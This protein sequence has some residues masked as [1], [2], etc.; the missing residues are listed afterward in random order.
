MKTNM[1]TR[2]FILQAATLGGTSLLLPATAVARLR[3]D[4]PPANATEELMREHGLLRRAL[5]VYRFSADRLRDGD[6]KGLANVLNRNAELFRR[7]GEDFHERAI[8]EKYV[9]P[10]VM[11]LREP[12]SQYPAILLQQHQRGREITDYVLNVTKNGSISSGSAKPL[13]AALNAFEVM[14][15]KHAAHEDTIVYQAWK[16]SLSTVEFNQMT[17]LFDKI[18]IQMIGEDGFQAAEIQMSGIEKD[19]GLANLSQFTAKPIKAS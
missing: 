15:Q 7:F 17:E 1:S 13:A 9:L 5:I 12:I 8:E 4:P 3:D 18:G 11:K 10:A 2:R 19:L 16:D 14:Y 6:T